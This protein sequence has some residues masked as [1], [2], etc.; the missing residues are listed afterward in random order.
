MRNCDECAV[1]CE[2]AEVKEG[3]FYK[4]AGKL[5]SHSCNG[6]K[7]FGKSDR[8]KVCSDY[9]CAW[10][11]GYG[12]INDRPDKSNVMLSVSDFN[13]GVWIFVQETERDA[14]FTTGKNV[15]VDTLRKVKIPVIISDYDTP[16]GEDTGDY[17]VILDSMKERAKNI[18]GEE[19][20]KLAKDI[21][22]YKLI[23]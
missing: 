3:D 13:G 16:F 8:P 20:R 5:C 2:I 22:V 7:L 21:T 19:I 6:C 11:R 12:D 15:I 1:C 9:Q 17:V 14:Y 10:S 23:K 18:A 4:P